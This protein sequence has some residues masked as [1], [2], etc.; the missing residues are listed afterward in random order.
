[1]PERFKSP[2]PS[3]ASLSPEPFLN[4]ESKVNGALNGSVKTTASASQPELTEDLQGG[5][6]KKV[7]KVVRR[8]VRRVLPTEEDKAT[9]PAMSPEPPKPV[10]EP[11]KPEPAPK[12]DGYD[13]D[14]YLQQ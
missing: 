1:M 3:R 14:Y 7:V 11:P 4:G 13:M 8:V 5:T 10:L 6:R 12:D 9:I 2:E